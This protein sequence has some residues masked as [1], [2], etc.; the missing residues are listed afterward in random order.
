MVSATMG[1]EPL[2]SDSWLIVCLRLAMASL[3]S[4]RLKL[5]RRRL[6]ELSCLDWY[7]S[8]VF[9]GS[10]SMAGVGLL[11]MP[12]STETKLERTFDRGWS[13]LEAGDRWPLERPRSGEVESAWVVL[14]GELLLLFSNMASRL[15]T[16]LLER[17]G[18]MAVGTER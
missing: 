5:W 8:F 11:G 12:C 15:R 9:C 4:S 14:L 6:A 10:M 13:P 16:W 7:S 1:L 18:D 17:F 3:P 2:R